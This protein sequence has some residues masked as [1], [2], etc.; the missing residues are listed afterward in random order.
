MGLTAAA[1]NLWV[2][3]TFSNGT[4]GSFSKRKRSLD[5]PLKS[6]QR[7]EEIIPNS[8][9]TALDATFNNALGL[10][11]TQIAYASVPNPFLGISSAS[12]YTQ[13]TADLSFVDSSEGGQTIPPWGQI[14]PARNSSFIVAR[15]DSNDAHPYEWNN[16]TNLHNT[17]LAASA[18][19]LPLPIIPPVSTFISRNYTTKPVF[20]GCDKSLTTTR[21]A[22]SPIVLYL[23]NAPYSAYMN[24]SAAVN[25][26]TPQ[27]MNDIFIN[28]FN[29]VTPGNG[30]LDKEWPI[31]LGCAAIERSLE[32][33]YTDST[34]VSELFQEVLLG[35]EG[36]GG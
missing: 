24:Y 8:T 17:Y 13:Q 32:K 19:G 15:E 22:R 35:W 11:L 6:L 23:A 26:M 1:W 10:N 25:V 4:E 9:V 16:G 14:Q 29:L 18:S 5:S 3:E 27:Q 12:S 30:T 31:C 21:D 36:G 2:I 20:F 33:R 7:H 28:S 34:A